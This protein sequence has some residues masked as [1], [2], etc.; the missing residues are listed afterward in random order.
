VEEQK[1]ERW[2]ALGA[3]AFLALIIVVTAVPGQAP[4]KTS[5]STAKIT[6]YIVDNGKELRWSAFVGAVA[7]L[8][9]LW[10]V[11]A[12]WRLLRRHEGGVPRLA[13][14]ALAGVVLATALFAVASIVMST[15]AMQL[16]PDSGG[17][18]DIKFLYLLQ[19]NLAAGAGFGLALFVGAFSAVILR[20][21]M[22]PVA[23]GW[24]GALVALVLVVAGA[25]VAST[26]DVYFALGFV[27]FVGLMLWL[28]AVAILMLRG[29]GAGTSEV[30]GQTTG[31]STA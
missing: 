3:L 23:L 16:V 29:V 26:K 5:D 2:S 6:K 18:H 1:W 22:M 28:L 21:R 7:T 25:G 13:V 24:F 8:L 4:P 31:A 19:A 9:L 27:G 30:T 12:V 11:G 20:S 14:V 15:T 10:W 17:V